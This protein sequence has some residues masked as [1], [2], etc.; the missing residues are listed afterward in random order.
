M[1][2]MKQINVLKFKM[3]LNLKEVSKLIKVKISFL[4]F[5]TIFIYNT[6]ITLLHDKEFKLY[7]GNKSYLYKWNEMPKNII[8]VL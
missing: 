5:F 6:I 7:K 2:L 4:F 3:M 8:M 1:N